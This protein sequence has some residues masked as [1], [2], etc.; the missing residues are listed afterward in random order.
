[1]SSFA[2][3]QQHVKRNFTFLPVVQLR[4]VPLRVLS[5]GD[6]ITHGRGSK[7]LE[8]YRDLFVE[9]AEQGG[10]LQMIG[11]LESSGDLPQNDSHHD[12][13]DGYTIN[14]ISQRADNALKAKPNL[15]L[16]LAGTNNMNN[17]TQAASA[18]AEMRNLIDKVRALQRTY[19]M[20]ANTSI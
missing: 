1:V 12:G 14:A 19:S 17:A 4:N 18:P 11:S 15:V 20:A 13:W 2:F 3:P 5:L 8:G 6:S 10:P 7:D 16:L 9:L